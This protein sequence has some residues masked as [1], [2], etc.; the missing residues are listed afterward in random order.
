MGKVYTKT[1]QKLLLI[2]VIFLTYQFHSFAQ[3]PTTQ[4]CLGAIPVCNSTYWNLNSY[5]GQGNYPTEINGS[6][7]TCLASGEL[8]DVWYT[9][10]VLSSGQLSF[11]IQ[12]NNNSDDYDW[13]LFNLTNANCSDIYGNIGLQVCCNYSGTDGATGMYNPANASCSAGGSDEPISPTVGVVAGQTYVLNVSNFSSSTSG[14][15]LNFSASTASIFDNTPPVFQSVNTAAIYCGT[16]QLSFNFSENVLCSTI[17]T[18]DFS[19]TGPGGPYTIT[20]IT[21]AACTSGG[22]MEN[23]FTITYFPP[24]TQSGT[25]NIALVAGCGSVTDLCGNVAPPNNFNFNVT[26]PGASISPS[27]A[28]VCPTGCVTLTASGGTNY[29]WSNGLGTNPVVNVCPAAT[30]TYFVTATSA[31]CTSTASVVVT[32]KPTPTVTVP[33]N[34]VVCNNGNVP[35]TNFVSTPAGG[36]FAW[37]NNNT[38]IGLGASGSGNVPAFTATNPGS[39]PIV[40]TITVTPTLNGCAGPPSSYTITVNPTPTV[41]VPADFSVCNGAVVPGTVFSSIPAGGSYT[42]TNSNTAIGLGTNGIGNVPSF[43]ASNSGSSPITATITVTPTVNSCPGTPSTYIITVNPTPTVVVPANFAVCN[44][45]T[46]PVSAFTSMT[47]GA[48]FAWSNNNTSIGLGAN[49][50]GNVP[51]FT[52][53]NSG[54]TPI[55]GTITV[56]PSANGCPGTPSTYIITINPTPTV[57]VP[58]NIVVCN[59]TTVPASAFSSPTPGTTFAWTNSNTAIGL[60]ANGIGDVPSFNATNAGAT[61]ISGTIIVTPTANGCTGTPSTYTITV[62]PTPTVVVPSNF[63]VCNGATVPAT[64]LSSTTPGATYSWTNNNTSIGL[65]ANGI[66][67]VPSFTATNPGIAP[68]TATITV[69]P[70]ANGCTGTPSS[71][72]ITVNPTPTVVVPSSFAICN[73]AIVPATV[74]TSPVA[75][76]TFSWTNSNTAIGLVANGN[77][78]VPSFTATNTGSSPITGTITVTPSANGCSGTP[79]SYTITVNPT[80]IVIVPANFAVC[81]GAIVPATAFTSSTPGST[82]TWTNNNTAIGL[83]GSGNG[84]VPSFTA[85]NTGTLPITGTIT[86]TPSANSCTGTPSTYIITVNP[87][88]TVVVP[89]NIVVCNGTTVNTT[90]FT[91]PTP[92]TTYSWTN[93]DPTIGLSTSGNGNMPSFTATNTGPLPVTATITVTPSANGCTG[94]PSTYTITVNPTA[95]VVVPANIVICN[96]GNV[97]ATF[98]TSTTPGATFAWTNS[99]IA[100]GLAASGNGNVPAFTATNTGSNPITAT[101]TVTPTANSCTGTPSTYTIT[102][103]PTAIV[104]VPSNIVICNGGTIPTAVF[105]SPTQG[106]TY[107]WTNNNTAIGLGASGIGNIPSFTATNAGTAPISATI[108]VTPTANN[109]T[110]TSSSYTIT[111]N[112]T[113]TVVVPSDIVICTGGTIP[114]TAFTGPVSGTTYAWTNNNTTIGLAANGNGD[115]PSFTATN[116]GIDPIYATI[117]VT[118]TA[119]NCT[120]TQSTYQI[121]VNPIQSSSFTVTTPVCGLGSSAVTYTGTGTND[122]SYTWNFDGGTATPVGGLETYTVH[123]TSAGIYN[124]TLS[125]SMYGC[126]SSITTQTVAVSNIT[127]NATTT[128]NVSCFGLT[129]GSA[130]VAA[131]NGLGDYLYSWNTSPPQNTQIANN[132]GAGTYIVTVTDS[133][134]CSKTDTVLI[135][136]PNLLTASAQWSEQVSCHNVSDASITV[137]AQGGTL[138]YTYALNGGAPQSSNVFDN[139]PGGTYDVLVTDAHGCTSSISEI[140]IIN[141]DSITATFLYYSNANCF[142]TTGGSVEVVPAGGTPAYTYLWSNN[143]TTAKIDELESKV[144]TVTVTD[145][146]ECTGVFSVEILKDPKVELVIH[147]AFSPNGD[148][149]NDEWF[150]ENLQLYPENELVIINRWG[151]EVY[152]INGYQNDWDGGNLNEGTYF[153]VLKVNMCYDITTLKGYITL[154]R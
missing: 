117:T 97:P 6:G 83:I 8:N 50:I 22:A 85:T 4:D 122:A 108:T 134:G 43:S 46:V 132:L 94:T 21:G 68:I 113:P 101:I 55:S 93:T 148:G 139:L 56:T 127:L 90:A 19:L 150:I 86:V 104:V 12:P 80:A 136:Q 32:V 103:N 118:P 78:N 111:V 123:W 154:L 2:A 52:A 82:F 45:A 109:C 30:T 143:A 91:S 102:V 7:G 1:I 147:N 75:G 67:D 44:G 69:T 128:E 88:P 13:A 29:T 124:I 73:G 151:N 146:R 92:G 119:N 58:S 63:A 79:S 89:A 95:S 110:G 25:Y 142:G 54:T 40:G 76:A 38:S 47:P 24:I 48:T 64:A 27:S 121:T 15:N 126:T 16:N 130:T 114:S 133:V 61:P 153:Y 28:S 49:G 66:G 84:D 72:I 9:F 129:D 51:A 17:N 59:G 35:A 99:N 120:G 98:F 60:V 106:T 81:N 42:W 3:T 39:T 20:A 34:I 65:G 105:T 140:F 138:P 57:S 23:T 149:K 87:T 135:T 152:S 100:I 112:P 62:N 107:T 41:N 71:Y 31:S 137:T 11:V 145:S 116:P 131:T 115:V 74:F 36:T 96:G 144:Y 18:C 5:S 26:A 125:V 53:T 33:S 70:S 10:T 37:T 141:P 14:Y 77:G